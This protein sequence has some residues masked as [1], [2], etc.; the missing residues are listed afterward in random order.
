[1]DQFKSVDDI[2]D[3]AIGQEEEAEKFYHE[4]AD[5]LDDVKMK[6]V[7][8]L[9]ADEEKSHKQKLLMVKEGKTLL[10]GE[11]KVMDLKIAD[12]VEDVLPKQN[13]SY[14][15][16]LILAM[17]KEKGAFKLYHDLAEAAPSEP[18]RQTFLALAQEEAKH[19]LRF[20]VEYDNLM[21]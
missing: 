20:E 11:Q 6:N 2:L 7:F 17:K 8:M 15:D 3:F 14:Q 5:S 16:A 1:M 12:Y 13:M 9:F 18:V 10:P 21:E 19:K 4:L